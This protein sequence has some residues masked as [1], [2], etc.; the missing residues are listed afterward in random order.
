MAYALQPR[1]TQL[2]QVLIVG[3]GAGGLE[4]ATRLGRTLGRTGQ[5]DV[6]LVDRKLSHVWKPLLH[7]V[8]AGTLNP[9]EDS[10]NYVLHAHRN[11]YRFRLG[12]LEGVDR[13][14]RL[15]LCGPGL[16]DMGQPINSS[17]SFQYDVLVLAV[18]SL[19]NDF[20]IPG[21]AKHCL[22]L[23]S[24]DQAMH[25]HDHL[26]RCCYAAND[27]P[28]PLRKGQL[29]VAIAGGG[30]TGVELA[31]E[32]KHALHQMVVIG[33]DHVNEK[34]DI[35]ISLVEGSNRI[36]P[37]LPERIARAT[38]RVLHK[39]DIEVITNER[40][41]E[42]TPTEFVTASGRRIDSEIK[43]W[44]AGI[45]A[46][47]ALRHIAGLEVDRINRLMVRPT[48]Q[49]TGDDC[50]LA[51]GDCAHCL[52]AAT[53]RPLP[54]RAQTAS[55]QAE[56]LAQSIPKLLRGEPLPT[57]QYKDYGSLINM[58]SFDTVGQL[59]GNLA[60]RTGT[61]FLE[62]VLAR[63]SYNSLYKRHQMLL[64]GALR[65]TLLSVANALTSKAKPRLKL[66]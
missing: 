1:P 45:K 37:G 49:T 6:S 51:F 48:L 15:L 3:G 13:E 28:E 46:P 58:S 8:A 17:R 26:L 16:D 5:A 36:L 66:H 21:V 38:E 41:V 14:K 44:A 7:E 4:L 29:R 42:A 33:L 32:L 47:E 53:G 63:I 25:F 2:K 9:H 52:D 62:G 18:G 24:R 31:A 56:T 27:Q 34:R 40:I 11:H 22:F 19:T 60:R 43:V 23:D 50:I 39:S 35:S 55:Q 54:P 30:A 20:G 61:V 10:V 65:T 57:F 64:Q 12:S 59:M